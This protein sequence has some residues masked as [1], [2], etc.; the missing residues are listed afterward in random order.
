MDLSRQ[1]VVNVYNKLK[2]KA[3]LYSNK[4]NYLLSL[5]H[6]IAASNWAYHFNFIYTDN[7]LELLLKTIADSSLPVINSLSDSNRFVLL[8]THGI[9]N[10]GLT[11]Q[12]IRAFMSME[13][14]FFYISIQCDRT[15]C[16]DIVNELEAYEKATVLLFDSMELNCIEKSKR[17]LSEIKDY[18]PSKIFLH[19]MPWD[20]VS[21][22]VIH[23]IHGVIK[24]NI[25]LT[26]HAFWLGATFIDF[27]LEFR[28]YGKTVSLEKRNLRESQLLYSPYYPIFSKKAIA[29]Q[30]FPQKVKDKIIIFTGGSFYKM[31]GDNDKF[32]FII[33]SLLDISENLI[34]L[35]AGAGNLHIIRKKIN[36]LK[37][38]DRILFLGDRKDISEVFKHCDIYL[39]TYPV[40]GGLMCQ[41][42]SSCSKPILAYGD[43]VELNI[44]QSSILENRG[45]NIRSF[46]NIEEFLAYANE[47][48]CNQDFCKSEGEK[49]LYLVPTVADFNNRLK[50]LLHCHYNIWKWK[51]VSIDYNRVCDLY[52][53]VEN[54]YTNSAVNGLLKNM[55]FRSFRYYPM[56]SFLFICCI[57]K[58]LIVKLKKK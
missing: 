23:A 29:F 39:Q 26:D 40:G 33:D 58:F 36:R 25:N 49:N 4:D 47:L 22:M 12:Y 1:D 21:L 9:D 48:I 52:L 30:G 10:R 34:L 31:F 16:K 32:F 8:E 50:Q 38:S 42:A 24:Y 17:I 56:K 44:E 37:N 15:K 6:I 3:V 51:N 53:D 19:L 43:S 46:G 13:V 11:Q 14:E 27:N 28:S 57:M 35:I 2:S 7:E 20:V 5:K 55:R 45:N 41:Y 54:N 18:N